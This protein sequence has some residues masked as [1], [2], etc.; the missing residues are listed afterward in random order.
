MARLQ[1]ESKR[2]FLSTN[3]QALKTGKSSPDPQKSNVLL[4][5][6]LSLNIL[7]ETARNKAED[8]D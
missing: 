8:G 5:F 1:K 2:I 4:F 3:D 7:Y 6:K